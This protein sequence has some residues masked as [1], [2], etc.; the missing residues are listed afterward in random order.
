MLLHFAILMMYYVLPDQTLRPAGG[1]NVA[2]VCVH[3]AG[4]VV[5]VVIATCGITSLSASQQQQQER[6]S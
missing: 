5:V 4:S 2:S 3:A 1:S 6:R